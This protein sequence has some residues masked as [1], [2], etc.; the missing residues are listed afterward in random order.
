MSVIQ[1]IRTKYA[2]L[3]GG[4]IA[5]ALVA[6]ILMDALSSR[7]GN[8]FGDDTSIVKVNGEKIDYIAY[9]Q[10]TK[11]YEILYG[12]SQTIDD[13][14]RAQLNSM[15]L[16]ELIKEELVK[17]E[18]EKLGLTI[19]EAEKKDMIYGNDPDPGVRNYQAFQNPDTKMFDP[20]YV[21]MF[22][23]QVDQ[24]DPTGKARQHWE[25]YKSYI[26]RSALSKKYNTLFTAAVYMPKFLVEARAKQQASMANIDYVSIS[27]ESI[28]DEELKLTD[29]DYKKYIKEHKS[30]YTNEEDTR[31]I[32]YVAFNVMPGAEDT[33]RA[34]GVLNEIRED[35]INAGDIESFVNRNSEESFN[36]AYLMKADYKSMYADSVYKL[37]VGTVLGPVYEN[38]EY[39]LIKVLDKKMYPDSVKCR[40]ILIKTA[41]RGQA[42]LEDSIAKRKIDSVAAAIKSGT[43]F[44]EMV[45]KYSDDPGS[46]ETGGEYSFPFTQKAGLVKEFSDFVFE[47]KPGQNTVVKVES[48]GYSGYHYIEILSHGEYKEAL[49][50]ATI[51]KPLYAGDETENEVY[52]KATEFA[53]NSNSAKAFDEEINKNKLQKLVADNIK[54]SDFT[55]YG[56]GPSRDIIK[57]MYNSNV[58]DVS[59]VFQL[60]GKYVVAKLTNVRKKGVMELD[61]IL[62][63]NIEPMVRSS[64]KAETLAKKYE[65]KKSLAE[66]AAA[67]STQVMPLDSFRG[68]NSFTAAAGYA[69]KLVGYSF[70]EGLKLN[71]MSKPIQG[72]AGVYF[73]SVKARYSRPEQDTT[74]ITREREMMQ[75]EAKNTI[76]SQITELLKGKAK[77]KYNVDNF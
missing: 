26:L 62:R 77:I 6:F 66:V 59:P 69:P 46:K 18:A 67:A 21:K 24:L 61:T 55:V 47:N 27:Y 72:Q 5:L 57:W 49:K 65:S 53:G 48:N 37:P 73:I 16:E 41:D 36:G 54:V 74:F 20:Q 44:S 52:A 68:N 3:A 28:S 60:T 76:S 35:F 43:P 40:H 2:K 63:A 11:E 56:I 29:E 4:V 31:A 75:M 32:E 15:A 34:L 58:G 19:T 45:Q 17:T 51:T 14:F 8:L 25:T 22:E 12:S 30:E 70:Y 42:V 39:K 71:T 38:E 33:A 23:E 64:K 1:K 13:N 9:S 10:R 50:L 7:S